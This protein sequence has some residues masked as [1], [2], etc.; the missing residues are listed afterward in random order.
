MIQ[1]LTAPSLLGKSVR[2]CCFIYIRM[3]YCLTL[4]VCLF[5]FCATAQKDNKLFQYVE[6]LKKDTLL[7]NATWSILVKEAG[8]GKTIVS[9]NPDVALMPASTMK[10]LTTGAGLLT[11]GPDYRYYTHLYYDGEIRDAALYGN[12][13][14]VGGGDPTLGSQDSPVQPINTVFEQWTNA[15]RE[16]GISYIRGNLIADDS[17][18]QY[19]IPESW[20]WGNIGNGY[21]TTPSGLMFAENMYR[22]VL[23][24]GSRTGD[25][26]KIKKVYPVLPDVVFDNRILAGEKNSGDNSIVFNAPGSGYY[27]M[28]GTIP[29]AR[30]SFEVKASNKQG[31]L[32]CLHYFDTYLNKHGIQTSGNFKVL[33]APVPDRPDVKYITSTA[34]LALSDMVEVVN[35]KSHNLYAETILKTMGAE[36]MKNTGYETSLAAMMHVFDSLNIPRNGLLLADGSGLSRKNLVTA[37]FMCNFLEEMYH[38]PEFDAF[39]QSLPVPGEANSSLKNILRGV[40]SASRIHAKSGSIDGARAYAGYVENN[41]RLYTFFFA[42]NNFNYK[43]ALLIP[44]MEQLMRLMAEY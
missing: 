24:S 38:S 1:T 39:Y 37:D 29:A 23:S 36:R 13:Y 20:T 25:S 8:T 44:C 28:A 12:I 2:V 34:S 7:K 11:L 32:T 35:K 17:F 16:L 3:R 18:F 43:G 21:G 10:L 22:L 27:L 4:V 40:H 19:E 42:F 5:S 31:P 26:T 6:T 15:L 14:V 41:G 33:S 9:Y 30:D